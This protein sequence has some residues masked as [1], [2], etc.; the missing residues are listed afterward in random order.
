MTLATIAAIPKAVVWYSAWPVA[1]SSAGSSRAI[2][3]TTPTTTP[4]NAIPVDARVAMTTHGTS[5]AAHV[6]R[7]A[8]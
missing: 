8:A 6:A 1:C 2:V 3:S 5:T 4:A 7:P